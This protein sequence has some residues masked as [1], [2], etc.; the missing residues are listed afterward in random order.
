MVGYWSERCPVR[1]NH[2][3]VLATAYVKEDKT[4]ISLASW[5]AQPVGCR[6]EINWTALGLDA[7]KARL[8]APPVSGFQEEHLFKPGDEI[9]VQPARGWLLV[10]DEHECSK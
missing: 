9:Q 1:T 3:D 5:A 2:K 6:L 10:V 7:T 4:L 8:H